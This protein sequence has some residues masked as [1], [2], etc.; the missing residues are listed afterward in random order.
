MK[1]LIIIF[2][3]LFTQITFAQINIIPEPQSIQKLSG[4]FT[5]T[6]DT[7]VNI[8]ISKPEVRSI[9]QF[10]I[11]SISAPTGFR[12]SISENIKFNTSKSINFILEEK[13]LSAPDKYTLEVS[14]KHINIKASSPQGMFYAVQTLMQ[15]LP[16]QIE[17]KS[18][19][20]IS[21]KV[22]AVSISD[23]PRFGWRGVMLD[24]SRHYF[25]KEYVKKFIDQLARLKFNSFHWHLTDDQGWRIEIKSY[26]KLTSVGA[27]RVQRTGKWWDRETPKE[28]EERSYGGFYTQDD[29]REIVK[30]AQ[31]RYITILPEIDVP[32]H[33]LAALASYPEF[34]CGGG[35]FDVNG[36]WKFYKDVENTLCPANEQVYVFLDKVFGEIAQLFP[37]PYIHVGGDEA[38][39][40]YWEKS[41]ECQALMKREGLKTLEELQSYFIKRVE[42]IIQS[43]GKRMI[44]WD[45][46]LEGGLAPDATVMSWRG[47]KGGITAAKQNHQVVMSPWEYV[48]LDLYQGDP[49]IEP[50]TYGM[51][52]LKKTYSFD[53]TPKGIDEKLILGGQ[54]NLW[55][56]SVP[57][58]RHL[59][60]M[61]YPRVLAIS[62]ALWSPKEKKNWNSFTQK[63]ENYFPRMDEAKLNYALSMYDA[64]VR[65]EKD[66][67]GKLKVELSTETEGLDIYYTFDGTNPDD[68][69]AKY[70]GKMIA[71]PNSA[72]T[73]KV[74]TYQNNKPKGKQ[75]TLT[76][77]DLQ[78]RV[79]RYKII[80]EMLDE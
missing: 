41:P 28:G 17:N 5:L 29:I 73:L 70:Q 2:S 20:K 72:T 75:I 50:Q 71:P 11:E 37:N 58:T 43:K 78:D 77:K 38:Y 21:W 51:A 80:A 26:P 69:S 39:K 34:A 64:I 57:T 6:K 79:G 40:G 66:D 14:T 33:S 9:A 25:G 68:F 59:E 12:P 65:T 61:L 10:F 52:R 15:L 24:V 3:L 13:P 45:E 54:G 8:P 53:P 55:T 44:G 67:K 74:I 7:K 1:K 30:Y 62:E 31:D 19:Q 49:N 56:E 60:Y 48:Y 4:E 63:L 47:M 76:M 32:G 23:A 27:W 42:K 35:K 16:K 22:P 18:L 36:G 46:I